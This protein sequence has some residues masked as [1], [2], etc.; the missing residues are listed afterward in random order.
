M[1][2]IAFLD[3]LGIK[4]I[5]SFSSDMYTE[6]IETFQNAIREC[7]VA[8]EDHQYEIHVFSDSTY[9][10][11]DDLRA[12]FRYLQQLRNILFL[13]EIFF[14]AAVTQGTLNCDVT[15][16]KSTVCD[17]ISMMCSLFKSAQTVRVY[18]MQVTFTG[19]GIY[20]DPA[21]KVS[22]HQEMS[23][24]SV[25]SAF[26]VWKKDETA[27]NNFDSYYD[28]KYA[29]ITESM[30]R[31]IL[32]NFIKTVTLNKKAA[33]YYLSALCTSI[34]QMSYDDLTENYLPLFLDV[35][36]ITKNKVIF[37]NLLP[38]HLMIINR[39]YNSYIES[40]GEKSGNEINSCISEC[41]NKIIAKSPLKD[42]FDNLQFYSDKIISAK[43][44][45]YFSEY[46]AQTTI[47]D[48]FLP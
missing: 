14:N 37:N 6:I 2:Y 28:I 16:E 29:N 3:L 9:I 36:G 18:S 15:T 1:S 46:I 44:K 10:E 11:C 7:R 32:M 41:L 38:I 27:F 23:D 40:H 17:K 25:E 13:N 35:K 22:N 12:L 47:N 26:C 19:V 5:A 30:V 20:V 8:F 31:F 43:N 33:R 21:L 34:N 42:G 39:L 45:Y 48:R 4:A 24:Y